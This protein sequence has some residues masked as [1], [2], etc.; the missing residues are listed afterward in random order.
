TAIPLRAF[1]TPNPMVA[2]AAMDFSTVSVVGKSLA[3][4]RWKH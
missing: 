2:G 1:G 3:L 4:R